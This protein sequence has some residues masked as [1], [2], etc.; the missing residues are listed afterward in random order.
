MRL[1]VLITATTCLLTRAGI[2]TAQIPAPPPSISGIFSRAHNS[3]VV[4]RVFNEAGDRLALGSGFVLADGRVVTNAHV[5][6]GAARADVLSENG[7]LLLT[8]HY[9]EIFDTETDI[10]ILPRIPNA[11]PGLT[12]AYSTPAIGEQVVVIGSPEGLSNSASN[13]I[14]SAVR[15]IGGKRYLQI[16]APISR[17]SSGG[18]VLNQR[19]EV[20]GVSVMMLTEG[21]N[22]NFAVPISDVRALSASP[23]GRVGFGTP[24][25]APIVPGESDSILAGKQGSILLARVAL[26][27]G[28]N[29]YRLAQGS[30][31]RQDFQKAI[32]FLE[33]SDEL[34]PSEDAKFLLGASAF[35]IAQSAIVEANERKSCELAQLARDSFVT[36]QTNLQAGVRKYPKETQ[37]LL[38]AI[39]QFFPSVSSELQRFCK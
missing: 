39:P 28:S 26:Q 36:A 13:G 27:H 5:V 16:T 8:T 3:V 34:D 17:G 23:P 22:L 21:Q 33:I 29:A 25:T 15:Q 18:P 20:V 24:E 19:G 1:R 9:A 7:Q 4:V 35:S 30:K 11:P 14:V 37:P 2:A 12:L 38:I 32:S 31:R 6:R 10:A